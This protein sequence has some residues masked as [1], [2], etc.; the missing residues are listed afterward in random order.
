[1]ED[2]LI[3][4]YRRT[5][6]R[7]QELHE[8][9]KRSFAA[10]GATHM[11]RICDPFRPYIVRAQGSRKWDVDGN[12]YIDYVMGHGA[13]ILGHSHPEIVKAVQEQM[14]RGVHYG[15]NH[16]L[17]V[18][19]AEL[20]KS[21]MPSAER[22]EFFACGQ[23]ANLMAIRLARVFT[24]RR[25]ILRFEGH[26]HGWADEL[27]RPGSPGAV[28]DTVT[29]IP[30]N[31]LDL[32]EKE[33]AT[34]EY[35]ALLTEA[36]GASMGGMVPIDH[37]FVRALEFLTRK[38]GTVWI[39]DEV[40]T[41]FRD[42]PGGWQAIVGV[43]PDLTTLGKCVGGGLPVG[44]LVGRADIMDALSPR[45][46]AGRRVLHS[47]TWNAN[48][49]LCAAGIAA[50]KIYKTGEPQKRVTQLAAYFR[51]KG[52]KALKERGIGA[53]LYSRSIVHLYLGP[54]DYEPPDDTMPPTRDMQKIFK[55]GSWQDPVR[56]RLNLH[57][58][59]R[60][61]AT[62]MGRLFVLSAAHTEEDIGRT[63]EALVESL[64]AMTAEGTLTR[65]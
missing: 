18:E 33:L 27:V 21:M 59:R 62:M 9:A 5:H 34:R 25:K 16:E 44:A 28:A 49:L 45:A 6:P 38:Y 26:F 31:D 47:G 48:P 13:L 43:R 36:G 37:D 3:E 22:V 46:P 2:R 42:S 51:K 56:A 14:A 4:E 7:S 11:G 30:Q 10:D 19:W 24:G 55:Q 29:C 58:L 12:E 41:G 65:A 50:C 20:I 23:E 64:E 1:M 60:G 61:I 53:R 40:V 32:V 39:L 63:V 17:E 57:L 8:R 15:E 52:N 35:A 54:I